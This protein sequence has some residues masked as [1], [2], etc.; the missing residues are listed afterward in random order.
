MEAIIRFPD[1]GPKL[2]SFFRDWP[3]PL[4]FN[5]LVGITS[6]GE[7]QRRINIDPGDP[8]E[9]RRSRSRRHIGFYYPVWTKFDKC[10]I[11]SSERAISLLV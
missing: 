1:G 4:T 11:R 2:I 7:K 6:R 8:E 9:T 3:R 10:V 5:W